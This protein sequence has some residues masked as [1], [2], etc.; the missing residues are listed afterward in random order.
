MKTSHIIKHFKAVVGAYVTRC[1]RVHTI[2]ADKQFESMRG[3][4][5]DLHAI[6]HATARDKDVPEIE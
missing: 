3:D 5:A 2:I 1:F 4:I 6:L